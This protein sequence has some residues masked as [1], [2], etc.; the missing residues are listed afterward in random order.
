MATTQLDGALLLRLIK[1][2]V[3]GIRSDIKRIN[4]LNVFP[5]PDGDTGTNMSR[6]V[7]SGLAAVA[8]MES[9]TVGD[10]ADAFSRGSLFG[11][12]GNSGVILSQYIKGVCDHLHGKVTVDARDLCLACEG[13]V[14]RAYAAIATPVEGTILTVL[15]ESAERAKALVSDKT[16]I[17]E[18]IHILLDQSKKTLEKTKEM[19]PVLKEAD[20][21]DSGGAGYVALG[22][23]MYRALVGEIPDELLSD[24]QTD[25]APKINY[26]LFT[27][28]SA[29]EWG[30][31]TECLVRMQRA[32]GDPEAFDREAVLCELDALGANSV[33]LLRDGDIL[34]IHA[35]TFTPSDIL[36][37]CQRYGEFLSV[38][39]ENMSLQHSEKIEGREP[40]KKRIHKKYAVVTVA[41]GEG[42][43]ALFRELGVDAVVGGGQTDNPSAEDFI[44]AYRTI[45]AD[46]IIV[47]PNNGNIRLA[48]EQSAKLYD[49][50]RVTVIPTKSIA[51]GYCALSVFNP[52][53][54]SISDIVSDMAAAAESVVSIEVA[55]A[56]RDVTIN[57]VDVK[58]G[59]YIGIM[60]GDLVSSC[61]DAISAV[62]D[63]ISK[64][65]D[66]DERELVTVFVGKD[67]SEDERVAMTEALEDSFPELE[68][69]VYIGEQ[70]VYG[71]ILAI[72]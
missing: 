62:T 69:Q 59:E 17:E 71:Y 5:V 15:R 72:E 28:D 55:S 43:S 13:G 58:K 45:D 38:K 16:T 46:E 44:E 24:E 50:G 47:L 14:K 68:V 22:I 4:D 21:V 57:G 66:I 34:K 39:I 37:L 35:H 29:L 18:F 64:I 65:S 30:Y 1:G 56:I 7:E 60:D 67:V 20:V 61:L 10:I 11:A 51:Q 40:Q 42:M 48:A 54:D 3:S 23:G 41:T 36:T 53:L 33:V 32:K 27:T 8:D 9:A 2:S 63:T 25:K 49:G 19:L 12:R 52:A 70:R 31:C 6:T 26:D